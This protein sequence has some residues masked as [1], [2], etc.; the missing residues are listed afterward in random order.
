MT[1]AIPSTQPHSPWEVYAEGCDKDNKVVEALGRRTKD[2][3]RVRKAVMNDPT[4]DESPS[5]QRLWQVWARGILVTTC[6]LD[7]QGSL[8]AYLRD[9]SL[10]I[11]KDIRM[12]WNVADE[13]GMLNTL[14]LEQGVLNALCTSDGY[15]LFPLRSKRRRRFLCSET[16]RQS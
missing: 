12:L 13:A 3:D 1:D 7:C 5:R 10:H 11:A 4:A 15:E 16:R 6:R 9:S 8:D 2:T 14:R